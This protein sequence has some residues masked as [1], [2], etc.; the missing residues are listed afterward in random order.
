MTTDPLTPTE[1]ETLQSLSALVTPTD[2]ITLSQLKDLLPPYRDE[3]IEGVGTFR[4]NR[5]SPIEVLNFQSSMADITDENGTADKVKYIESAMA[6][7]SKSLGGDFMTPEGIAILNVLPFDV[8]TKLISAAMDASR[9]NIAKR[10][11]QVTEA[12]NE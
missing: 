2:P 3:T 11:E 4:L 9:A 8:Q 1:T 10:I 5:L 7:V 12:K 6:F